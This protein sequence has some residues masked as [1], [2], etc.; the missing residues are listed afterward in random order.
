MKLEE[1]QN[2]RR[3]VDDI[4]AQPQKTG[5]EKVEGAAELEKTTSYPVSELV[6]G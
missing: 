3:K 1:E 4:V 2:A 6:A 5:G